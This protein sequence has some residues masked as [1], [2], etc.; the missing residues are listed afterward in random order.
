MNVTVKKVL[1]YSSIFAKI[2][3]FIGLTLSV[4]MKVKT[5]LASNSS[6]EEEEEDVN[7][8]EKEEST[9]ESRSE[10]KSEA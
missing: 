9:E 7:E 8:E 2:V 4:V 10:E 6:K 5:L 3:S 1:Y